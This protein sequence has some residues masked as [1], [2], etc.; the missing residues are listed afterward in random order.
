[1]SIR[2]TKD[3]STIDRKQWEEF[4]HDH[5]QGNVF[6]TPQMYLVYS[7]TKKYTP[8]VVACYKEDSLVGILLAV[9]QKEYK[10]LLGSLSARSIIWG[11]P[12]I[13]NSDICVL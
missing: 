2:I 8:I 11:G 3:V 13:K 7:V 5:P 10:G 12:L 4:V 9:V 6:Q 1:M